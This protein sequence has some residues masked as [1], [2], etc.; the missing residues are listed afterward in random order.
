MSLTVAFFTGRL[1]PKTEWFLDSLHRET[2]GNYEG[3]K[4]VIVDFY[5]S[6]DLW[7]EYAHIGLGARGA[8]LQPRDETYARFTHVAPKPTVWQGPHR[9]TKADYFAAANARNTAICLAPD[10]Y[11]A[12]VDD[13][14]V[15]MPGWLNAVREAQARGY[16]VC[17]AY[18]KLLNMVVEN[19]ELKSHTP[20][21]A[22]KDHRWDNNTPLAAIPCASS[23]TYGCSL[24]APVEAFLKINGYPEAADGL[25]YEDAIV[26]PA[27]ARHGYEIR[28][29][30]R[31]LTYESE[32][33]HAQLPVMLRED[34]CRGDQHANPRDDM[35]HAMLRNFANA[36]RFE[37]YFGEEGI[38]G[39][40]KRVLAGEPF[41]VMGIPQHR[42][43]DSKPLSEL[44]EEIA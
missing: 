7:P 4:V 11:I 1:Q 35:S 29:D 10:G 32:E 31:M 16:I 43:F 14:S 41:P 21:P 20:H 13:L 30:R 2:G 3:I 17:G 33:L 39:L 25:G 15:L 18:G 12:F 26:G 38:R 19:G 34:P 23:W 42:W 8:H 22:G 27:L 24:G 37:N 28:F 44:P 9:L 40:R 6:K 36:T 5:R